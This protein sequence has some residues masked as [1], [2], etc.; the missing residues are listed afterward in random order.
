M[1]VVGP[2]EEDAGLLPVGELMAGN[3]WTEEG[4]DRDKDKDRDQGNSGGQKGGQGEL[5]VSEGGYD[6]RRSDFLL[7]PFACD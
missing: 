2:G 7:V 1:E 3:I 4:G 5:K 6:F